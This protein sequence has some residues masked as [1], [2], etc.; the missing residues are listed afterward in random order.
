MVAGLYLMA[1][2]VNNLVFLLSLVLNTKL[3]NK[4]ESAVHI[5]I[6]KES[7]KSKNHTIWVGSMEML[8]KKLC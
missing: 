7:L 4:K 2:L 5:L 3:N 6:V 1:F 8:V